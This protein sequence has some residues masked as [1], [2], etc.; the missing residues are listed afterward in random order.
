MRT[1]CRR[2]KGEATWWSWPAWLK[3][4]SAAISASMHVNAAAELSAATTGIPFRTPRVFW[5]LWPGARRRSAEG[6]ADPACIMQGAMGAVGARRHRE[7]ISELAIDARSWREALA[8][9]QRL[10]AKALQSG[11]A[12]RS[13]HLA[14]P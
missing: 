5:Q 1:E 13:R 11:A 7:T 14:E 2:R 10:K 4:R 6:A 3:A 12:G 9:T 8:K